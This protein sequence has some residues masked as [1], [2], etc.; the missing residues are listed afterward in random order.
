MMLVGGMVVMTHIWSKCM[1]LCGSSMV[2]AEVDACIAELYEE[3]SY[4]PYGWKFGGKIYWRIAENMSFGG[5]YF[6]G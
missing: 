3:K 6:G 5:I 4:I 2:H 1:C